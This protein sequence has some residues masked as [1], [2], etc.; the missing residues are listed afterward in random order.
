MVDEPT[1]F[2]SPTN[3]TWQGTTGVVEYGGGD[4]GMFAAFYNRPM[5]NPAK[6]TAEG[7]P[8]HENKIFIRVHPPGERWNIVDRPANDSDRRR[9]PAQWNAFQQNQEQVP[10]GTPIDLLYPENPAVAATMRANHCHTIEQCADLSGPAIENIGMGAQRYVNDA[11]KYLKAAN[12][13]VGVVQMRRE[14]EERDSQIRVLMQ[15]VNELNQ[16]VAHLKNNTAASATL[17]DMRQLLASAQERPTYAPGAGF[18]PAT[19]MINAT[20]PTKLA[21]QRQAK[22]AG[23]AR[24]KLKG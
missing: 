8:V 24:A 20:S 17:A 18:D 4:K 15:Q 21:S 9:W 1:G 11:Q 3:I 14:L 13:G 22:P 2:A 6:S 16:T 7:R 23:R 10:E 5:H 19:A 12:K